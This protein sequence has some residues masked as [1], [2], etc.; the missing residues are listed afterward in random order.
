[1]YKVNGCVAGV[2]TNL[3]SVTKEQGRSITFDANLVE[4]KLQA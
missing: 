3:N 4:Q 1:M 2:A